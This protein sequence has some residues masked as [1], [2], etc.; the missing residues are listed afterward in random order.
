MPKSFFFAIYIDLIKE[1]HK[2]KIGCHVLGVFI[3]SIL[4][5]DDMT[6]LAAARSA[7][8]RLSE[9]CDVYCQK[10]CLM[11]H[12]RQTKPIV[13]GK[14]HSLTN[15]LTD[16]ELPIECVKR[17]RYLGFHVVSFKMPCKKPHLS[18]WS[19]SQYTF[20]FNYPLSDI[21]QLVL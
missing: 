6:V 13:F 5:T 10:F 15:S 21:H 17:Y 16:L 9:I 11:L 18:R 7:M 19:S 14:M 1:L 20:F 2:S 3:A 12:V 4:F 8:Q